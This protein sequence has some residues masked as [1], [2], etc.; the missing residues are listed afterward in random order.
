MEIVLKG[1]LIGGLADQ[2]LV[3]WPQL[4]PPQNHSLTAPAAG[5]NLEKQERE[6]A[7]TE[8]KLEK[9]HQ[10]L[11]QAKQPLWWSTCF[12]MGLS[13]GYGLFV[14]APSLPSSTISCSDLVVPIWLFPH[15]LL[16]SIFCS[17]LKMFSQRF[18]WS[19]AGS[20]VSITVHLDRSYL[21][22]QVLC[23]LLFYELTR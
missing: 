20:A 6:S 14:A 12:S 1:A 23:K 2:V 7:W 8:I 9:S 11:S 19:W 5:Q 13:I 16:L 18:G 17:L 22:H 21:R 10:F 15:S 3:S 4:A